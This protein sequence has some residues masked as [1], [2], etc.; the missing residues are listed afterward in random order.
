[1]MDKMM[2]LFKK[3]GR[4]YLTNISSKLSRIDSFLEKTPENLFNYY[5]I[6]IIRS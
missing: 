2:D 6:M 1:M 5:I 4:P 3:I